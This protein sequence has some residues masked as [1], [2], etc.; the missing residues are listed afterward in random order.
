MK[1]LLVIIIV[2]VTC[3][4]TA[5]ASDIDLSGMSFDELVALKE[6]INLALWSS[7]EWQEVTVPAGIWEVGKDI[8]V[9][10]WLILPREKDYGQ[11][12]YCEKVDFDTK[13]PDHSGKSHTVVIASKSS[14]FGD[15]T[16]NEIDYDMKN[17]W[18]FINEEPVIFTPYTGKP[19]LGFK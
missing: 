4:G 18:F 12:F 13:K 15:Q 6:K 1:R 3:L 9:G 17:G 14:V 8:P 2:C 10:H 19:D 7:N 16:V 5:Y 11:V